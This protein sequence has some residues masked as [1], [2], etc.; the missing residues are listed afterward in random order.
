MSLFQFPITFL[1]GLSGTVE[2]VI[3]FHF[4]V[5]EVSPGLLREVIL[6]GANRQFDLEEGHTMSGLRHTM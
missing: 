4:P 3:L 5:A 6:S 2:T 1:G